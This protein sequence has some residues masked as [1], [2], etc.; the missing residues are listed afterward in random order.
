MFGLFQKAALATAGVA[1][2]AKAQPAN[3]EA[4]R[5]VELTI[6][7]VDGEEG[8]TG[9]IKIQLQPD[10]APRGVARFEVRWLT[11]MEDEAVV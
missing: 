10:W 8:K 4:G 6:N 1:T 3:A 2:I 11:R 9:S 7:N 5:I